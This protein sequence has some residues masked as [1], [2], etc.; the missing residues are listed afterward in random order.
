M[1]SLKDSNDDLPGAWCVEQSKLF[2]EG[3][4]PKFSSSSPALCFQIHAQQGRARATTLH[5][6]HGP[7][8]APVFMPVGT[9]GAI[10]GLLPQQIMAGDPSPN[11]ILAN[12]YHCAL[13]PGTELLE[14]MGG[15]HEFMGWPKNL[16]TDSGGFQMVSLLDL[17]EVTEEGVRF[18]SPVDGTLMN[19]TPEESIH[20]QN[21]QENSERMIGSDIIMQLD[22]VISSVTTNTERFEEAMLR[23]VRWLDRC[24]A[25]H[26]KPESQNLFAIVQ[27]G[28]D[29]L[30]GG[31]RERCLEEMIKR[32]LPGYAIG[33]LAG[34]E[35]KDSF[36]RVVAMSAAALP[37]DKPR[38][39]M[40]VGYPLD[41][42]VCTALGCDMYDC[43]YP[44]RTARFGFALSPEGSVRLKSKQCASDLR[45]IEFG[46]PC[47]TCKN[48]S[49]ACLNQLLK[50]EALGCQLV[51]L[52]NISYMSRL[53]EGMRKSILEQRFHEFVDNFLTNLFPKGDVPMWARDALRVAGVPI[54][55]ARSEDT[56]SG[57]R[58]SVEGVMQVEE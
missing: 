44:T 51:T 37:P 21:R 34:G 32:D 1:S 42:V 46:C 29:I 39:L 17:S 19:L 16:L 36:W 6:P 41:L 4:P 43:V 15:L 28:L 45:P 47:Q 5:L 10:K 12:T 35:S 31:L 53:M 38:Y 13:Q 20:H 23:S 22:D 50:T 48:Y 24:V 18:K 3:T 49:R 57:E 40:G 56:C 9:K 25:A 7:V 55:I 2:K 11:I 8:L 52:H 14:R 33:G 54:T 26:G 30:P 27:G 58:G